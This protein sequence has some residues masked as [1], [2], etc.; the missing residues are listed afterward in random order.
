MKLSCPEKE[1][2]PA[3]PEDSTCACNDCYYMKMITLK[4]IYLS[5]KY[6]LPEI[7]IPE[8][9]RLRALKPLQRML[10]ISL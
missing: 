5:L 6:E 3:P 9:L 2:I 8:E 1:L 7:I 10:D 4:K